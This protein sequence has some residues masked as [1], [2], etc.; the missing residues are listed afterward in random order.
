MAK[1]PDPKKAYRAKEAYWLAQLAGELP[2]LKLPGDKPR[3]SVQDFRG[4]VV[5]STADAELKRKLE[6]LAE[7]NGATLYMV[8]LAAYQTLLSRY[9]GQDDIIVG[10]PIVAAL[11]QIWKKSRECLSIHWRCGDIRRRRKHFKHF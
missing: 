5:E 8:L 11:I 6:R 9:S 2:Y 4:G 10:S 3:P 7:Q 1:Q